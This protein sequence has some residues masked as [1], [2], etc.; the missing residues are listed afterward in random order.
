MTIHYPSSS[1]V[2]L[3]YM[4]ITGNWL[5]RSQKRQTCHQYFCSKKMFK[6]TEVIPQWSVL[7][8]EHHLEVFQLC[9]KTAMFLQLLTANV[10][11]MVAILD[12]NFSN[13]CIWAPRESLRLNHQQSWFTCFH[14]YFWSKPYTNV[15]GK[16]LEIRIK[17]I[18]EIRHGMRKLIM[19][20]WIFGCWILKLVC[21]QG[22][23]NMWP[24]AS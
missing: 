2:L 23:N 19:F 1:V 11:L 10:F 18:T 4:Y 14:K 8:A 22:L 6:I 5:T 7:P 24:N 13:A 3:R 9:C 15:W 17:W 20:L 12:F 21:T 16:I